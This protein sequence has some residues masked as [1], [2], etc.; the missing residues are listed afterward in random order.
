MK[1]PVEYQ[2]FGQT[3]KV[4]FKDDLIAREDAEGLCVYKNNIITL[5]N[6][7]VLNRPASQLE[8]TFIHE[9]LHHALELLGYEKEG[10]DEQFIDRLAGLLH[11]MVVTSKYYDHSNDN[12]A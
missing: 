5:Q 3:I 10:K 1:I 6:L 8:Q 7:K 2:Q 9:V 12:K 11:Q 4:V